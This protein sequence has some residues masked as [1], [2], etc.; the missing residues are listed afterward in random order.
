ML[1][2]VIAAFHHDPEPD[3][4]AVHRLATYLDQPDAAVR[5]EL[6]AGSSALG[7]RQP[8]VRAY[9]SGVQW[10]PADDRCVASRVERPWE[11]NPGRFEGRLL[12]VTSRS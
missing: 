7:L 6:V 2:G 11:S 9:R 5:S 4:E 3:P 1:D 10:N 12:A 8:L